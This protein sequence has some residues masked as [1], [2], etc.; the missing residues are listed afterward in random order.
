MDEKIV[1]V[2]CLSAFILWILLKIVIVI[3]AFTSM[4]AELR[5]WFVI[6]ICVA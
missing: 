1:L 4:P 3:W 6:L 2:G 5:P